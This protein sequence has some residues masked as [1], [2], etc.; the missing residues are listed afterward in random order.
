MNTLSVVENEERASPAQPIVPVV[1]DI[2]LP[3]MEGRQA[4]E[5]VRATAPYENA[6]PGRVRGRR[7]IQTR[8]RFMPEPFDRTE[9]SPW[10]GPRVSDL[11]PGASEIL[12]P[13]S[14]LPGG[15]AQGRHTD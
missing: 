9:A 14:D 2:V 13:E 5:L 1:S 8:P 11:S 3:R 10:P 7:A 12:T 4:P 6:L 15:K